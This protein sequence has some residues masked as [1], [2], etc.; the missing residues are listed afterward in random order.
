MS[1]VIGNVADRASR[2]ELKVQLDR[3]LRTV[4]RRALV[5]QDPLELVHAYDDPHDQ[6]VA[7]FIV[8]M[9]AYGRVASI[10]AKA[11]LALEALG[12]SP[13]GAVDGGRRIARLDGFVY[14]FQRGDDLPRFLR[15]VRQVRRRFGSLAAAFEQGTENSRSGPYVEAMDRFIALLT[16]Q[17]AGPPSYG[18]RYLLP[19]TNGQG[20]AKRLC[21]Y[22]RWMIRPDDGVDLGAWRQL[23]PKVS[24]AR[25]IVPLDTHIGRIG[26]NL[27]LIRR[28]SNDLKTALQI[29]EALRGFAPRDP[30][31]YDMPLCHLGISGACP[32]QRDPVQCTSCGLR[33]VCRLGPEPPGWKAAI[34]ADAP[35]KRR[36]H[37]PGS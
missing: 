25:L 28:A 11:K 30:L 2:H 22:L 1:P 14:R 37:R 29:T 24:A 15:S 6:E 23:A 17:L 4:D 8:A 16:D 34:F 3:W 31:R 21:L 10:R 35:R 7:G 13:A 36:R 9:L 5:A 12:P 26:R 33:R 19:R 32:Q 20:A 18:L 27:G